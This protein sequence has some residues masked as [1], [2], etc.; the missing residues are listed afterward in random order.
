M[1]SN[2]PYCNN[3]NKNKILN[4]KYCSDISKINSQLES[5]NGNT[6]LILSLLTKDNES[7]KE[8]LYKKK[9]NQSY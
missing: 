7:F 9:R 8:I 5:E 3:S 6:P 4:S 2:F 1:D